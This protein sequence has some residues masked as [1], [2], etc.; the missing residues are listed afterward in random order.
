MKANQSSTA[1]RAYLL[2]QERGA[3]DGSPELDWYEA[4][5]QLAAM[6]SPAGGDK[7]TKTEGQSGPIQ[8]EGDYQAAERY[9]GEVAAFIKTADIEKLA[10]Q[11]KPQS[12][13]EARDQDLAERAGKGHSK[14][15]DPADVKIMYTGAPTK[16]RIDR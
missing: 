8:G 13:K 16:P 9:R 6:S 5:R 2:W 11:A 7:R 4:E 14:G 1:V 10:K 12:P 15:D 3:P